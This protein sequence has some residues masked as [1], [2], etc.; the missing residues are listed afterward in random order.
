MSC[1][2]PLKAFEIYYDKRKKKPHYKITSYDVKYLEITKNGTIIKR[3]DDSE[4]QQSSGKQTMIRVV[5]NFIEIPCGK[6]LG[7]RLDYSRHWADRCMMELQSH[8]SSYFVTLTYDDFH[9][10]TTEYISPITGEICDINTL[11]KEDLRIFIRHLRQHTGQKIRFFASGEYGTHSL[12]PHFHIILFGLKLDDL[13]RISQNNLGQPYYSSPTISRAW[14]DSDGIPRGFVTVGE[15]TYESCAYTAR[16][17]MKKAGKDNS[18]FTDKGMEPEFTSMSTHPGI[19]YDYYSSH[20]DMFDFGTI[21]YSTPDGGKSCSIPRYFK[22]QLEK[23]DPAK[24]AKLKHNRKY[25]K[26]N[27]KLKEEQSSLSYQDMLLAEES[28]KLNSV[29]ALE[30]N[31]V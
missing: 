24:F 7:C 1:Y 5:K 29:K 13:V 17:V 18:L 31:K 25:I 14:C 3:Y 20:Q 16:Y 10:P 27:T 4:V 15:V 22:K 8:E 9:L 2:H 11:R 23:D 26:V 19:A 12:R 28:A 21:H 30:R 6:C